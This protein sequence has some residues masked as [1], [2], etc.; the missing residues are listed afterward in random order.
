MK[1]TRDY[2]GFMNC[3]V[4]CPR[5]AESKLPM[6]VLTTRRRFQFFMQR[7]APFGLFIAVPFLW[8]RWG[9]A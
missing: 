6:V 9:S 7:K 3:T 1:W 4:Y 8:L 2:N 5:S